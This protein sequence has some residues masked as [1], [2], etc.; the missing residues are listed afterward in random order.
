MK[1]SDYSYA[2]LCYILKLAEYC[3]AN[4]I[5]VLLCKS[6]EDDGIL[7][8]CLQVVTQVIYPQ[9]LQKPITV[10]GRPNDKTIFKR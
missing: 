6:T 3:D 7:E 9:Q 1:E 10:K 8:Q 2:W 4:N 5:P